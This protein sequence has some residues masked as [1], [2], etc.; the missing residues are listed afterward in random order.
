MQTLVLTDIATGWTECGPLLVREQ[1]LLSAVL[2]ELRK[3][4]PFDLLGFD[5]DNGSVFM[6]ETVRDYCQA[7]GI[8]FTRCRPYRKNDQAFVEQK[9]GAVVER[10]GPAPA[11][12]LFR[13]GLRGRPDL[14]VPPGRP[15]PR[16]KRLDR[17]CIDHSGPVS[18]LIGKLHGVTQA[19]SGATNRPCAS[20]SAGNIGVRQRTI[21]SGAF[22]REATRPSSRS[23]RYT[24]PR[25]A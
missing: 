2:T 24:W 7:A 5:T 6:N 1:G 13:L 4:L 10:V 23:S 21:S 14:P 18:V 11:A 17:R 20:A 22:L 15:Q 8:A 16:Q 9:N 3:L 19:R 12:L 25:V